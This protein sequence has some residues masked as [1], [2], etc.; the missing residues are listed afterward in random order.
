MKEGGKKKVIIVTG[1]TGSGKSAYAID[2][3]RKIN[4]VIINADAM[5]IYKHIPIITA[6]PNIDDRNLVNHYLYSFLELDNKSY[7]VGQYIKDL[8]QTLSFLKQSFPE[9]TPIIVG[10]TMLYVDAIINGLNTIPDI[11]QDIRD[12]VRNKYKN[13][14]AEDI[15]ADLQKI[16]YEYANIVDRHNKQRL[17]RGIEVKLSTGKSILDFWKEKKNSVFDKEYCFE[18]QI[19]II[20]REKLYH[21]INDRVDAMLKDGLLEE[22]EGVKTIMTE[23]NISQQQLPKAIGLNHL[24]D[25]LNNKITLN[26]AIDLMKKD[27]RHYAKRQITWWRN[28]HFD[29]VITK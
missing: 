23:K 5:Q 21:R 17:L 25:Y 26:V 18:K 15:F 8:Q 1:A 16:D 27:S 7:S 20:D 12:G 22:V 19:V 9:K 3:A 2:L 4:G 11:K 29:K 10:G 24:L 6:Q 14:T 28:C 13:A